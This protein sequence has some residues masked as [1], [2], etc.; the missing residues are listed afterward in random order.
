M[1]A[2]A[3]KAAGAGSSAMLDS[4]ERRAVP[5]QKVLAGVERRGAAMNRAGGVGVQAWAGGE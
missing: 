4:I 3:G 5:K 2:G 1:S